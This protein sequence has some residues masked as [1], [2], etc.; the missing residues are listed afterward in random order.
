[1][2]VTADNLNRLLGLSGESL[3]ESRWLKPFAASL[4]RLKRLHF[5]TGK[6]LD[7]LRQSLSGQALSERAE[8]A[9]LEVEH[10]VLECRQLLSERLVALEA[11]DSRSTGLAQRLYDEALGCRMRPFSDTA[12][13]FPRTVR[14]LGRELGKPVF[15]F[16]FF[17]Y[18]LAQFVL[19]DTR[20]PSSW[21][22]PRQLVGVAAIQVD[23][24][25]EKR[26][27]YRSLFRHRELYI[28]IVKRSR[29]FLIKVCGGATK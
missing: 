29:G 11:F 14:D 13:T 26:G 18:L 27:D 19:L 23:P 8:T 25:L 12:R 7:E 2:R 4:L 20:R 21:Q 5:D 3:V 1:M 10:R 16:F 24:N 28:K 6:T 9:L 17:L 22:S 15:F